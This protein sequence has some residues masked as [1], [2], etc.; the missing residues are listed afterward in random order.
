MTEKAR[1]PIDNPG[2]IIAAL[3]GSALGALFYNV[4]PLY[5][6]MAQ[7]YRGL[8]NQEIGIIGSVFFLGFNLLT[9]SAFFWIRRLDWRLIGAISTPLAAL[10][11]GAGAYLNSYPMLL[12]SVFIAGGAFSTLYGLCATVLGDSDNSA[13]WFGVKIAIESGTGAILFVTLPP[14]VIRDHGFGGLTLALAAIVLILSPML[15]KLPA[16]GSKNRD[17]VLADSSNAHASN[18]PVFAILVMLFAVT[19]WFCGETVMWS[20]VERIGSSAGHSGTAVG[21]VLAV[22]L[23]F[24]LLGALVAAAV[25]DRFGIFKPFIASCTIYL[26]ALPVLAQSSAFLAYL[27]G[28]CMLLFSAGLGVSYAFAS[29]SAL[30]NDG[31]YTILV[32]PA[33]GLGALVAPGVAGHLSSDGSYTLMLVFGGSVVAIALGLTLLSSWSVRNQRIA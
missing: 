2:V 7:E 30:D 14:L 21:T 4:L 1:N 3:V 31:R 22:T 19:L 5:L 26:L 24:S 11:I 33:I 6:G 8:S 18:T 25:G 29:I 32:V 16:R 13:R 17:D 12:V 27:G 9:L 23:G 10:A 28:A 20:F 15:L